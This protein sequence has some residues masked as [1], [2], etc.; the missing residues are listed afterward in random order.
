MSIPDNV[1][2]MTRRLDA[3]IGGIMLAMLTFNGK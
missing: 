1:V 2:G 3:K